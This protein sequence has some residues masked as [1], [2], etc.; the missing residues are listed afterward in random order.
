[1]ERGY[2]D[3]IDDVNYIDIK[4]F[5][6]SDTIDPTNLT[7]IYYDIILGSEFKHNSFL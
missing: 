3:F 6:V 5:I 1:M 2:L 7:K 4:G